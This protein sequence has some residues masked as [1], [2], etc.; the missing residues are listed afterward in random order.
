[1]PVLIL[2]ATLAFLAVAVEVDIRQRRIPN[3]VTAS[4]MLVGLLLNALYFG[5]PGLLASTEGLL[6]ATALLLPPFALGGIGGG[7][8]K[9]MAAV[10]A[11][12]GPACALGAL[13][14]GLCLGG[15]VMAV[16]LARHGRLREKLAT[17]RAML[18]AA[19]LTGSPWPLRVSAGD[20]NMVAL[21][22]SIPLS[23]GTLAALALSG[24]GG[25]W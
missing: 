22:Y 13:L 1:M 20:P 12:L 8:V 11:L 9:M 16:H 24:H 21:P 17:I 14:L 2:A 25:P 15:A 4:G 3:V 5:T 19:L 10:G 6:L 18:A 23:L 7:D